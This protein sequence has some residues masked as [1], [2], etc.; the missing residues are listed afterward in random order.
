MTPLKIG[1]TGNIG[2]GKSI[3]AAILR[4]LGIP[5]YDCDSEAKRLMQEDLETRSNIIDKFGSDCYP[6]GKNLDRRHLA[7]IIFN[8]PAA[9]QQIN[10]IVHPRVREDFKKWSIKSGKAIVAVESAILYE[11]GLEKETDV[12]ITIYADR[13]TCISRAM[14]RNNSTAQQIESRLQ[15]Q[16]SAEE[17]IKK[18]DY[19]ICN[20]C[21]TPLLPQIDKILKQLDEK[22]RCR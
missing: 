1:L 13:A 5:V 18:S 21:D 20:N 9:L 14:R 7:E 2:S 4:T 19:Y 6:D 22:K 15:Q 16:M 8:N 17:Q 11:A 12:T 10:S 3:V